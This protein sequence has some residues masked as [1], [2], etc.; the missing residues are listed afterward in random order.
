M[1]KLHSVSART[2]KHAMK[3]A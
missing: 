3:T 2:P 1:M